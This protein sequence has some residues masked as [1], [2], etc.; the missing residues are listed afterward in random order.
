[1]RDEKEWTYRKILAL[2]VEAIFSITARMLLIL[3][4]RASLSISDVD[5][6]I[7]VI[8][9]ELQIVK[10]IEVKPYLTIL[11]SG[12]TNRKTVENIVRTKHL[13]LIVT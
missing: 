7:A 1:M 13:S 11:E 3:D 10:R 12:E 6:N 5:R 2:L 4:K 8:T 9:S